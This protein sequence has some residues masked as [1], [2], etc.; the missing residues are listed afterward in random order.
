MRLYYVLTKILVSF[1]FVSFRFVFV[2]F[3]SFRFVSFRSFRFVSFVSFRSWLGW[4]RSA[5]PGSARAGSGFAGIFFHFLGAFFFN[6]LSAFFP[7]FYARF[8]PVFSCL[9]LQ[10]TRHFL[11]AKK[12][13]FY[14]KFIWI[15]DKCL[16]IFCS[17]YSLFLDAIL[18]LFGARKPHSFGRKKITFLCIKKSLFCMHFWAH[19][20]TPSC[21]SFPKNT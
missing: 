4:L 19:F 9:F 8:L 12:M 18:P 6:F 2:S 17:I 3:R 20:Q 15:L 13:D 21:I 10:K 7:I 5:R 1:R 14:P 16:H 11:G